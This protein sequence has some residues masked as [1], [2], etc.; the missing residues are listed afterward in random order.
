MNESYIRVSGISMRPYLTSD[1]VVIVQKNL[2]PASGDLIYLHRKDNNSY[3]V[4]RLIKENLYKGDRIKEYDNNIWPQLEVKG[5]VTGKMRGNHF[6]NLNTPLLKKIHRLQA[7]L[8]SFNTYAHPIISKFCVAALIV[9][10]HTFR[11]IPK[12]KK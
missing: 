11:L 5:V 12:I 4:H 7:L 6:F 2:I 9:I 8:S 3:L 1:D 10:G